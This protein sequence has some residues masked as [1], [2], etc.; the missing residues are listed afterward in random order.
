MERKLRLLKEKV[1]KSGNIADI[2]ILNQ[3]LLEE[4][5][6]ATG[7]AIGSSTGGSVGSVGA[8]ISGMG[9]V[10]NSQPSSYPGA[11]NGNAWVSGGGSEGS[12]DISV[13]Y[14]PSG[15]NRMF[16]KLA[17]PMGNKKSK[18]KDI[19]VETPSKPKKIMKFSEF[20][21]EQLNKV[22]RVKE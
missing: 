12:G 6:S 20:E 17:A 16:Q 18:R 14:N 5:T 1:E 3:L 4:D 8:N 13:A 19:K 10:V 9:S 7:G 15:G 21:K 2:E 11:L 22:T